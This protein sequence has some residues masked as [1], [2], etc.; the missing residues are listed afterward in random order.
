VTCSTSL[1]E[2]DARMVRNVQHTSVHEIIV[3]SGQ[4]RAGSHCVRLEVILVSGVQHLSLYEIN[5]ESVQW[6]PGI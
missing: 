4:L 1:Y 3:E 6:H 5:D 2:I